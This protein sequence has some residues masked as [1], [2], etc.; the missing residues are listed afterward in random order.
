MESLRSLLVQNQSHLGKLRARALYCAQATKEVEQ[1]FHK[2][3]GPFA[4]YWDEWLIQA[5]EMKMD[6]CD[7]IGATQ[8]FLTELLE[9]ILTIEDKKKLTKSDL[10]YIEEVRLLAIGKLAEQKELLY[11]IHE[12]II[13]HKDLTKK[14]NLV[15]TIDSLGDES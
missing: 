9:F 3:Y 5:E 12:Q 14:I 4:G 13:L 8:I 10:A 11:S 7:S 15:E 2:Q 1:D 6:L